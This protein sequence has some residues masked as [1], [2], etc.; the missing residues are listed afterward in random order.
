MTIFAISI[1]LVVLI[2]FVILGAL[3]EVSI[4]KTENG[5]L[6]IKF[7]NGIYRFFAFLQK[8]QNDNA[9]LSL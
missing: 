1:R 2:N 9:L 3:A 6:K 8:A 7:C 4:K 5:L